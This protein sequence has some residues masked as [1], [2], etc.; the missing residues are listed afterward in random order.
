[1]CCQA[2]QPQLIAIALM[3]LI[4]QLRCTVAKVSQ[5]IQQTFLQNLKHRCEQAWTSEAI[6]PGHMAGK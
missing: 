1:M 4:G 6:C 5:L 3:L 2:Q